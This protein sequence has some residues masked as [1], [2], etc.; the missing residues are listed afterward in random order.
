VGEVKLINPITLENIADAI[1]QDG[2]AP[3]QELDALIHELYAFAADPRTVAGLA[4][5]I[6]VWG[7]RS[8]PSPHPHHNA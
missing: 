1:L 3:R 7:R 5:V 8:L 4:R 6:Q 2:L